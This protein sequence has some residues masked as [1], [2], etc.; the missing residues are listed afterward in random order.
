[1]GVV[2]KPNASI[3]S[4][5]FAAVIIAAGLS[6]RMGAFKPLIDVGG[7]PALFRLLDAIEASGLKRAVVVTGH[8]RELVEEALGQYCFATRS[9]GVASSS[10]AV[11]L[12]PSVAAAPSHS[13]GVSATSSDSSLSS[14]LSF[15]IG[16]L[17]VDTVY[18]AAFASGMFSSVK[19]GIRYILDETPEKEE[20]VDPGNSS[21]SDT[22]Y[23]PFCHVDETPEEEEG[24]APGNGSVSD[25][26]YV[27]FCLVDGALL[28]PAD[29][30]LV[31]EETVRGL[32]A[33][34]EQG[35]PS[36][37]A[38]PVYEGRNGRP[39]LIPREYSIKST[40]PV[41]DTIKSTV[42]VI[43]KGRNGHPLLIPREYFD[44]ILDHTGDGGLKEIRNRHLTGMLKYPVSDIGCVLDMDTPEDYEKILAYERGRGNG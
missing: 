29:V 7:K 19:A 39:L 41:I 33:A 10:S 17:T 8:G 25:T 38:V 37:F 42:P 16:G 11:D 32:I 1:M 26:R 22:G 44:E 27:P 4:A 15:S 34:Y 40:V 3:T 21:V 5:R 12:P 2:S 28:F 43:E 35:S 9:K 13:A 36:R 6:S 20:G 31:S 23:V 24:V 30:P 14:V 18:N